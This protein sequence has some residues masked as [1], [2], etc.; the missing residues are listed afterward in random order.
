MLD[1]VGNNAGLGGADFDDS[2]DADKVGSFRF[3]FD[4][5]SWEWSD[6][7]ARLHGYAPGEVEPTTELLAGH[8]H[9]DDRNDFEHLV[10]E[11]ATNHSV[12]SSRHRIIDT[13]GE[14]HHIMVIGQPIVDESGTPIGTEGFY[15]DMDGLDS[16][17]VKAQIDHHVNRFRKSQGVIEQTKGMIMF[18]YRVSADQA[19]E[20]LKWR[21]Q[22]TNVKVSILCRNII[23]GSQAISI[24]DSARHSFDHLLLTA[25]QDTDTAA[26]PTDDE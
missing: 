18:T 14:V 20:V 13:R 6:E 12:F 9:P 26:P 10:E 11:M 25:H 16:R 2:A 7:V 8:K 19:F 1:D 23:A 4:T 17:I 15:L 5:Q 3:F 24:P 21:S 22:V